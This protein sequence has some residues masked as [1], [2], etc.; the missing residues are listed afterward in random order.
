MKAK[1]HP[2]DGCKRYDYIDSK[3]SHLRRAGLI[4]ASKS[5]DGHGRHGG[6]CPSWLHE[7]QKARGKRP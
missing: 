2:N 1:R 4:V 6:A 3:I 7:E 5:F